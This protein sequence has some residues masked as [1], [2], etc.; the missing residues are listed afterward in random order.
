LAAKGFCTLHTGGKITGTVAARW[1]LN[2]QDAA[3]VASA[4]RTL[5]GVAPAAVARAAASQRATLTPDA[6]TLAP[7]DDAATRLDAYV[8]GLRRS[9][10]L[11]EFH[12]AY[13]LRRA[14]ATARGEGLWDSTLR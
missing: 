2:E 10:Q 5:A 12:R 3:R 8:E 1:W 14:A 11:Q 13:K 6:V 4:A 7:A 9:G